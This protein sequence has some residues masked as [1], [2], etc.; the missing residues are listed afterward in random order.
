MLVGCCS[1]C[2]FFITSSGATQ[3]RSPFNI[4][5]PSGSPGG[6]N[7]SG[8]H[9]LHSTPD[10]ASYC[11]ITLNAHRCQPTK[12]LNWCPGKSQAPLLGSDTGITASLYLARQR[13]HTQL[14]KH[15]SMAPLRSI[16]T[17]CKQPVTFTQQLPHTLAVIISPAASAV[18]C[19]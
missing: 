2:G 17:L 8:L 10:S 19:T 4:D 14:A 18:H 6:V 13:N 15:I 12:A 3:L 11:L 7:S 5:I 16:V 1:T 9:G